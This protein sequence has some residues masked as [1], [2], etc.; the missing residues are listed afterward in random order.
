MGNNMNRYIDISPYIREHISELY[1]YISQGD[2]IYSVRNYTTATY[3]NVIES[4]LYDM[5]Y[6]SKYLADPYLYDNIFRNHGE[7]LFEPEI[8]NIDLTNYI[9]FQFG[10]YDEFP[11]LSK[12][13]G[14]ISGLFNNISNIINPYLENMISVNI[15]TH[16]DKTINPF[17]NLRY[18]LIIGEYI[19]GV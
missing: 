8:L 11:Y 13:K 14:L 6:G 10:L 12:I 2:I 9:E 4:M 7:C 19:R 16:D 3:L 1:F 5:I 18:F 15:D 17:I